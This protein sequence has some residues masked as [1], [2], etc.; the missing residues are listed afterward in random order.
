[1]FQHKMSSTYLGSYW[2]AYTGLLFSTVL[3][4]FLAIWSDKRDEGGNG[5]ILEDNQLCQ[6]SNSFS[7]LNDSMLTEEINKASEPD[8]TMPLQAARIFK[9]FGKK[10]GKF[11]A[12]KD[13]SFVV[14]LGEILGILGP[15]GAGKTTILRLL[16]NHTKL[17]YGDVRFFG[18]KKQNSSSFYKD[19]GFCPQSSILW[20]E[21]SI[22]QHL[23]FICLMKNVPISLIDSFKE[24]VGLSGFGNLDSDKL[25]E[26]MKIKLAFLM[27]VIANPKFKFL[28]ECSAKVD[29]VT[30]KTFRDVILN[31]KENYGGSSIFVTNSMKEA[32]KVC[33]RVA[34]LINGEICLLDSIFNLKEQMRGFVLTV[35]KKNKNFDSEQLETE[36]KSRL[37]ESIPYSLEQVYESDFKVAYDLPEVLELGTIFCEMEKIKERGVIEDFSIKVRDLQELYLELAKF[38]KLE[39]E[40]DGFEEDF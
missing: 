1:M 35:V 3:Y 32:E 39:E 20:P 4:L 13:V 18:E 29:P 31:Q 33:D 23:K 7:Q 19:T 21:L 15:N 30:R 11:F 14:E 25:S 34:I 38:Q 12:V 17:S 16:S 5:K 28:D 8:L 24:L 2:V 26:G 27:S 36:I 40:D 10:K 6:R 9:Q 37:A 22:D